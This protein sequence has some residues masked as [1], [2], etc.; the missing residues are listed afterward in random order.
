M[1]GAN[2]SWAFFTFKENILWLTQQPSV[3]RLP[4]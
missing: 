2:G 4:T 1:V 3:T